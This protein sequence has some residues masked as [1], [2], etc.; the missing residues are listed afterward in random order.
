MRIERHF[1]LAVITA[2]AAVSGSAILTPHA[3]SAWA[4]APTAVPDFS[5]VWRHPSLPGF[6]PPAHGPG[7][8]TN[9]KRTRTGTSSWN[10]LVGDYNSPILRPWAAE[11]VK[12]Y[13]EISKAGLTYPTASSQ[14]WPQPVPY[15]FWTFIVEMVQTPDHVTFLYADPGIQFRQV[16]LNQPH[17]AH[18]TPSWRGDAVGHYE[19]DTLVIDTVGIKTDQRYAMVDW[20]GTPYTSSL[21]VVERY[22]L[23]DYAD[24]KDALDRDNKENVHVMINSV[25][26]NYRG[27]HLQLEFTVED[28]GTFTT[29]WTATVTYLPSLVP[30]QEWV[31]AENIREYHNNRDADVPRAEKPD[32]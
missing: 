30:W 6:E 27:K 11:I 25:D 13:G 28:E 19:G 7:P 3:T 20:F 5:G 17:P 9:L 16:R 1:L 21:H 22:R 32:F 14:C 31:C 23:R 29:P 4:Q 12:K 24:V 18:V 8:V 10:E 15:I 26:R 2:T